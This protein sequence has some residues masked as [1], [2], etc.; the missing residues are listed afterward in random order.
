MADIFEMSMKGHVRETSQDSKNFKK[1]S[2]ETLNHAMPPS[3]NYRLYKRRFS[4]ILSLVSFYNGLFRKY[5]YCQSGRDEHC[6]RNGMALVW[7][8]FQ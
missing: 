7:P 1:L 8:Y 6:I 5:P 3:Y 2:S 4:G